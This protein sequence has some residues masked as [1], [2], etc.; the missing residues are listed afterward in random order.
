MA[1]DSVIELDVLSKVGSGYELIGVMEPSNGSAV[2]VDGVIE[3]T[4][5]ENYFG[6]D[7]LFF[8]VDD[9]ELS[10]NGIIYIIDSLG[11]DLC[12]MNLVPY[13]YKDNSHTLSKLQFH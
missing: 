4:P 12:Y 8:I 5:N 1:E 11:Y 10:D 3:Y 2:I 13:N 9:G 6:L 7:E